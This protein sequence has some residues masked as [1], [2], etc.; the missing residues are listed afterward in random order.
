MIFRF[1]NRFLINKWV[2][3][4]LESHRSFRHS[5]SHAHVSSFFQN[6]NKHKS[7]LI[8]YK[9]QWRSFW[10]VDVSY[11][12]VIQGNYHNWFGL[13]HVTQLSLFFLRV[14][15]A[16]GQLDFAFI[17]SSDG[18]VWRLNGLPENS[19]LRWEELRSVTADLNLLSQSLSKHWS[20]TEP[21]SF[22][23]VSY[24]RSRCKNTPVQVQV[25]HDV[26][27][28]MFYLCTCLRNIQ[29]WKSLHLLMFLFHLT[30]L[31][32]KTEIQKLTGN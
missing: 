32:W 8:F 20:H 31:V 17:S 22:A 4:Q 18:D 11:L 28:L 1:I 27:G 13:T 16:D 15:R 7:H 14:Q 12:T 21:P 24:D 26:T 29:H 25:L 19:L 10:T 30:G 2:R 6:I 3:L 9:M 5:E 23:L